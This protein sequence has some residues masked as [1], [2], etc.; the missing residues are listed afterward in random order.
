MDL[1]SRFGE[2][3]LDVWWYDGLGDAAYQ[4]VGL[5]CPEGLGEHLF[6]DAFDAP[7]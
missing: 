1:L 5:K 3:V 2:V 4:P 6:A 7:A